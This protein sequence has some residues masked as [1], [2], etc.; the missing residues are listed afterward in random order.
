LSTSQGNDGA[1]FT[2]I[3]HEFG[4]TNGHGGIASYSLNRA[5]KLAKS[6]FKLSLI[7]FESSFDKSEVELFEEVHFIPRGMTSLQISKWVTEKLEQIRPDFTESSDYQGWMS[8]YLVRGK[9]GLIK[10]PALSDI[11]H[12]TATRE[13]HEW[14]SFEDIYFANPSTVT[15]H[16]QEVQQQ[17]LAARNTFPSKFLLNYLS[18]FEQIPNPAIEAYPF[19]LST[20]IQPNPSP[21]LSRKF[22]IISLGR[23][24][25]RK[26]LIHL[27]EALNEFEED[28]SLTIVGNTLYEPGGESYRRVLSNSMS[29]HLIKNTHFHDFLDRDNFAKLFR[30]ANLFVLPSPFENF[31]YAAIEAVKLDV[32][33]IASKYSGL[34]NFLEDENF[35][36][37]P[38]E[39]GDLNSRINYAHALWRD[40]LLHKKAGEQMNNLRD[41]IAANSKDLPIDGGV[42]HVDSKIKIWVLKNIPP[43]LSPSDSLLFSGLDDLGELSSNLT[44]TSDAK[45]LVVGLSS[46]HEIFI[47]L[48]SI[49]QREIPFVL[50]LLQEKEISLIQEDHL[51]GL[52]KVLKGRKSVVSMISEI[53]KKAT[54]LRVDLSTPK[55]MDFLHSRGRFPWNK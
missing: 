37:S 20:N 18:Q 47:D 30:S 5:R 26:G 24:E 51:L 45:D 3:V 22:N 25:R 42:T 4:K 41:F 2:L 21:Q 53:S 35:L 33:I 19:E 52:F 43:E 49:L 55:K 11:R 54:G 14:N 9:L 39:T 40:G 50:P 38:F 36:F 46:E 17:R 29:Q 34:A 6:G 10:H 7:T 8:D 48:D 13:I 27:I 1:K 31:P 28:F 23:L 12:H 44:M 32:P 16:K 15:T